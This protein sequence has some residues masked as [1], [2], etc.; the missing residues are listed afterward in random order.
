MLTGKS[1]NLLTDVPHDKPSQ[2]ANTPVSNQDIKKDDLATATET[3][4]DSNANKQANTITT[5]EP[6]N[7]DFDQTKPPNDT[8][9]AT[10]QSTQATAEPSTSQVPDA[11]NAPDSLKSPPHLLPT[12]N[13]D[14]NSADQTKPTAVDSDNK[15]ATNQS[16]KTTS[17]DVQ[18]NKDDHE[19]PTPT[20]EPSTSHIPDSDVSKK[21]STI[22]TIDQTDPID[23][24]TD[25]KTDDGDTKKTTDA[26]TDKSTPPSNMASNEE[27]NKLF[28]LINQELKFIK[29]IC[30]KLGE[31]EERIKKEVENAYKVYEKLTKEACELKEVKDLKKT[32]T[33]LKL[34]IPVRYRTYDE[35]ERQKKMLF[36]EDKD[37]PPKLLKQ[38][39]RLH[40]KNFHQ[41]SICKATQLRFN[42]LES[43]E[44]K[45]CLLCFSVFPENSIIRRRSVIYWW[46]GEGLI[47]PQEP[48]CAE[49]Y[50]NGLFEKL[51]NMGFIEPHGPRMKDRYVAMCKMHPMIRAALV[52]IADEMKL[53]DFDAYGDPKDFGKYDEIESPED[54]P[55]FYPLGDPREFFD[56]YNEN[57]NEI[58][59]QTIEI[60]D[61][62]GNPYQFAK[63]NQ[64]PSVDRDGMPGDTKQKPVDRDGKAIDTTKKYYYYSR[65]PLTTKSY[66]VCLMGNGLS[67]SIA[68]EKLHMLF[69]VKDDVLEF[70]PEW[71]LRMK[72]INVLF[73]GRWQS[74]AAHHIEVEDF[75]LDKSLDNMN[76]VKFFSLQGVSRVSM[77][78]YSISKLKS[79]LILDLRACHNLVEIPKT[80]GALKYLTHLDI[81]ECYLLNKIPKEISS[82]ESLQVLKG[83][84][85]VESSRKG[86]CTLEDLQNLH[87]LRK[88][89]MYTHMKDFPQ[90][91]HLYSLQNLETLTKLTIMW[92]GHESNTTETKKQPKQD[93][94]AD[95]NK[96]GNLAS[97]VLG[98]IPTKT[99]VQG[100]MRRKNA[101]GNTTLGSRLEKLDLKCFPH[102]ET[103]HWLTV[104]NLQGLKKLYIRGGNFSD[105]GQYQDLCQ[106]DE[107]TI[108]T[109]E[110]WN[111]E[112][113]RL[114]Y[115]E[116]LGM[117]WKELRGLFP[118]LTS[119]EKVKCPRMTLF[120]C[121]EHGVWIKKGTTTT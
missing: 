27:R 53:F 54:L 113:L 89:S 5:R 45:I 3:T 101:F 2:N 4:T 86:V 64:E 21:D 65:K 26:E 97:K 40:H 106:W 58:S 47:I 100:H 118:K 55:R 60:V 88:L 104:G 79:L 108:V 42:N 32:A 18:T 31:H 85:V 99:W 28:T 120:P 102:H 90:A 43:L 111:V 29:D 34:Q 70:K 73:L 92:G 114:K 87:N 12:S 41:S 30:P 117:E 78:P 115:L 110:T 119:L 95:K 84:V 49:D 48:D 10:D 46:I 8:K 1:S 35:K 83:F 20:A 6:S 63:L 14:S 76:Y 116:K 69:N 62:E 105:L 98:F 57:K 112:I 109:K 9:Q 75:D 25:P 22:D 71:F 96:K 121:D 17:T 36:V 59:D 77:L 103:P 39:P 16:T 66:K 107:S 44:L 74:S 91:T 33:K 38:L 80:I 50:A 82:L 24:Q 81:S 67:K 61:K 51:M 37:I 68:W 93:Q 13:Q 52:M 56:Y 7:Q 94:G 23:D 11:T 72:N 19:K 15:Q